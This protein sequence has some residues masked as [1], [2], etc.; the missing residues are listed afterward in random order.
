M[1]HNKYLREPLLD[2]SFGHNEE[3]SNSA[4]AGNRDL[5]R[6]S[7]SDKSIHTKAVIFLEL[8]TARVL[9]AIIFLTYF[10]FVREDD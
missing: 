5:K 1:D 8:L 2:N 10:F 6:L 9:L 4:D 7:N 3:E